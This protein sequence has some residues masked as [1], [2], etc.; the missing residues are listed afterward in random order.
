MGVAGRIDRSA[1]QARNEAKMSSAL[2]LILLFAISISLT[3]V[4]GSPSHGNPPRP[5]S[6]TIDEYSIVDE[7]VVYSRWRTVTQRKVRYPNGN[8]VDFDVSLK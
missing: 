2:L 8:I 5:P 7:K 1:Q 6:P 3:L 4:Q